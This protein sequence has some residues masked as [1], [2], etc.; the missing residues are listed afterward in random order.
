M[1]KIPDDEVR[2]HFKADH[3]LAKRF[4]AVYAKQVNSD[5][6]LNERRLSISHVG[7]QPSPSLGSG[8]QPPAPEEGGG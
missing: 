8:G 5:R 6:K 7:T 2:T 1:P 4:P 3:I